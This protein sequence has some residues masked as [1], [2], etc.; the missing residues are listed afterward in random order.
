MGIETYTHWEFWKDA[1]TNTIPKTSLED[2]QILF[3][4]K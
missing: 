1:I 4:T 3:G 2:V